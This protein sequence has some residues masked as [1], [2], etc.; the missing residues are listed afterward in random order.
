MTPIS[1][2]T[3]TAMTRR[4][5][6]LPRGLREFEQSMALLGQLRDIGWHEGLL[7]RSVWQGSPAPWFTYG[8]L[9]W[10]TG[11]LRSTDDV[12]EYGSGAS[13]RWLATQAHAVA[14][15]E[16][17]NTWYEALKADMP[18]NV[19]VRLV[20]GPQY[21][22]AILDQRQEFD[23]IIIDGGPDRNACVAPT[24]SRLRDGGLV[25]FDDSDLPRH[26]TGIQDLVTA[27][28][29]RLDFVGVRSGAWSIG[30][31]SCFS[32]D[33]SG[34]IARSSDTPFVAKWPED[35]SEQ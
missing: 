21:P 33:L 14:S 8:M 24:L 29:V 4:L 23:V 34:W 3:R 31:T 12:F 2:R 17:S 16:H 5:R 25:I 28:M 32:Y 7:G 35:V 9:C 6:G 26:Q 11:R 30:T 10:L 27:G 18:D 20:N 13:T 1:R 19:S 15:I 22:M